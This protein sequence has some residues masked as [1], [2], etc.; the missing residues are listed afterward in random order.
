M[1]KILG[2]TIKL[3]ISQDKNRVE[4]QELFLDKNGVVD[5]KFYGKDIN[6]SVLIT[7]IKSYEMA[8]QNGINIAYGSLGENI[9]VDFN[10]YDLEVG[11]QLKIANTILQIAQPCTLCKGL[12]S[13]DKNLPKL[14]KNDRGIFAFVVQ[15]GKISI[16]DEVNIL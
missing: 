15:D 13:V 2:K 11:T 5:D 12:S 7:S 8:K 6:R 9:L 10:P 4:K 14:L 16:D 1:S 3:F